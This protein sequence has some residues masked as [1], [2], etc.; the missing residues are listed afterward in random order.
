MTLPDPEIPL[1]YS[2]QYS[3]QGRQDWEDELVHMK[4]QEK[5]KRIMLKKLRA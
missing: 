5:G 4:K 3:Q 1:V 2:L